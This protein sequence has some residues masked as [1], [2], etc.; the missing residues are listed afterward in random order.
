MMNH[1]VA[2]VLMVIASVDT[3]MAADTASA[4]TPTA[5]KAVLVTGASTGIGRKLTER[6]AKEGYFVYAG[7][8]KEQDLKDLDAI[9]NVRSLRLDVTSAGDIA[10]AVDTV[11]RAGRGLYALVNN[12]G[13]GLGGPLIEM[14]EEDFHF[15]MNVNL[16]G[17]YRVTKA[18]SPLIVASKGRI[19]T[20][21]SISGILTGPHSGAY[22]MSKH[23]VEAFA[24][25]LA[26]EMAPRGVQ[27]SVVEPGNYNSEISRSAAT[28]MGATGFGDRSRYKEPDEVAAVVLQALSEPSPKRRY[29]ITPNQRE[30]E[31]TI[32]KAIEIDPSTTVSHGRPRHSVPDTRP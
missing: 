15:L 1:V 31:V 19:T 5:Q 30:A 25:V 21:G 23:A 17:P 26:A 32:R 13:V 3:A 8:R 7:A 11:T 18:F 16:Y 28:R 14:K 4:P 10:A 6:L 27:V 29:M 22:S 9:P 12:A 20:I 2:V 24:D